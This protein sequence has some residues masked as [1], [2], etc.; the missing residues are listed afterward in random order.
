MSAEANMASKKA[1]KAAKKATKAV[2]A[3]AMKAMKAPAKKALAKKAVA[4][5]AVAKKAAP[6]KAPAR[7]APPPKGAA[8]QI[9]HWE[10]QAENPDVLHKFY[11]EALG[12]V[13]DANNEMKYGMVSSGGHEGIDGGIGGKF[14]GDGARTRVLVYAS[15]PSI[16]D[17]LA[18]I[19][20]LGGKTLMPRTDV[21]PV[22]MALYADPEGNTMG[23]LEG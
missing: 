4:K 23:L 6:K 15:V 5:K 17:M 8:H 2:K 7:K 21:G 13:I 11:A 12:W 1:K 10:I 20:E 16:V 3:P 9:V 18:R 14:G 19:E 22:I